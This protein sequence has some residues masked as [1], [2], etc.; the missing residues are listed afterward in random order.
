LS[1]LFTS[2]Q[3]LKLDYLLFNSTALKIEVWDIDYLLLTSS[4]KVRYITITFLLDIKPHKFELLGSTICIIFII[5]NQNFFYYTSNHLYDLHFKEN[6]KQQITTLTRLN[7][8]VQ[9]KVYA[10]P[11]IFFT[12][13]RYDSTFLQS[14]SLA[15]IYIL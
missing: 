1:A 5:L 8:L 11:C 3:P 7:C 2:Y 15:Y 6:I 10:Y 14:T 13:L 4:W 9:L 12:S